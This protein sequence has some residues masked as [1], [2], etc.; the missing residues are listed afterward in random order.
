MFVRYD[1]ELSD[2]P[3]DGIT[4]QTWSFLSHEMEEQLRDR[5]QEALAGLRPLGNDNLA[6]MDARARAERDTGIGIAGR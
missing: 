2:G 6:E 3:I 5:F 4:H 1:R